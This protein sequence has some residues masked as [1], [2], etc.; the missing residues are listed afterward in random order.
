MRPE[1][2]VRCTEEC[3]LLMQNCWD[4]DASSRPH[5]GELELSLRS[6]YHSSCTVPDTSTTLVTLHDDFVDV[7]GHLFGASSY[8]ES[9]SV[10]Q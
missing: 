4:G 2:P 6:I 3:W 7:N 1:R 10:L 5:I 9:L 8:Q